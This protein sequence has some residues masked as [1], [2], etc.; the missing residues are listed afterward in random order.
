MMPQLQRETPASTPP[1][2]APHWSLP[3]R[4]A[5]RYTLT[6]FLLWFYPYAVGSLG[7]GGG[8]NNPVRDLWHVVVPWVGSHILHLNGYFG[9]IANGS[10]DQLYDYVLIFCIVVIAAVAT[11]IWSVLDRK[12]TNYA[13]LYQWLRIIIRLKLALVMIDYGT[14][15]LWRAQFPAPNLARLIE[16]Y[17]QTQPADLMW[18]FM[19]MSRAYSLFGGIGEMLGG[20]LL[21]VPQFVTI[22]TLITAAVMTNVF[23]LNMAYDVPRKILSIHL[24]LM[25]LFLVLPDL[26]RLLDFFL[27]NRPAQLTKPVSLF[28][29]KWLNRAVV[30]CM[31]AMGI[32]TFF[33]DADMY[34]KSAIASETSVPAPV[35]GIWRV[36]ELFVDGVFRPP[37]LTDTERWR[38]I[39][40]DETERFI[41][42]PMDGP[43]HIYRLK[44]NPD[45]RTISVWKPERP[46]DK[47]TL[48]YNSPQPDRLTIDG[49]LNGQRVSAKLSRIDLSD[50]VN[51][52]LTNRGF[53]WVN[54]YMHWSGQE[55]NWH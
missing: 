36:D 19:G 11:V 8:S 43:Q 22:G 50:P 49:Q 6:Y 24:L 48:T 30:A 4:I 31:L 42:E 20:V 26:R 21:F 2:T 41:V 18:T 53:H 35:R 37:M 51:F 45:K 27:L 23:I 1:D 28:K 55:E 33:G 5:F 3:T 52:A 17:G 29:D 13:V 38:R 39:V 12:R 54:L 40:L 16:P 44:L 25:C 9:E 7:K 14:A 32:V 46:Y 47:E 15:K 34:S 10:G